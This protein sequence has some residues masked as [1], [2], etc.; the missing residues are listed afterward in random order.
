MVHWQLSMRSVQLQVNI[1]SVYPAIAELE[2]YGINS[3]SDSQVEDFNRNVY[4]NDLKTQTNH[5]S[6]RL[7]DMDL[8]EA[9]SLV[10][11]FQK[12]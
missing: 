5:I 4:D 1:F 10:A 3:P 8:L 7:P 11:L 9:F 12:S 6:Y 2:D